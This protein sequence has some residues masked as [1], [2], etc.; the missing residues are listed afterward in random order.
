M[1][2][3]YK[4]LLADFYEDYTEFK[5]EENMSSREALSRTLYDFEGVSRIGE[6]QNN[7]INIAYGEIILTQEKILVKAKEFLVGELRNINMNRMKKELTEEEFEDF[8]YKV[9]HILET[10]DNI[11]TTNYAYVYWYYKEFNQVI[12]EFIEN[13][14]KLHSAESL[15]VVTLQR[16]SRDCRNTKSEKAIVYVTLLEKILEYYEFLKPIEIKEL[17]DFIKNFKVKDIENEQLNKKEIEIL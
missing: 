14:I 3:S 15:V 17:I 9:K 12:C 13:Q 1:E 8:N 6:L 5:T 2:F 7:T 16:F 4:E 11:E 10:I